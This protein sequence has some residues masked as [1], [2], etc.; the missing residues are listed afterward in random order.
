[1]VITGVLFMSFRKALAGLYASRRQVLPPHHP[2]YRAEPAFTAGRIGIL[3]CAGVL[4]GLIVLGAEV[5]YL[6]ARGGRLRRTTEG[7]YVPHGWSLT[8]APDAQPL[9]QRV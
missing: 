1:M 7:R 6:S 5:L 2:Q 3:G 9:M 4:A 8:S